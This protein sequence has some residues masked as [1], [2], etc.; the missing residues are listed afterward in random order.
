MLKSTPLQCSYR[1][2]D[3]SMQCIF[4]TLKVQK[5]LFVVNINNLRTKYNL[6]SFM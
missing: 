4:L 3:Y 6:R 1:L 2:L 5:K